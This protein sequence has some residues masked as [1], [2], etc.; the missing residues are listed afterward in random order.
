MFNA[1]LRSLSFASFL[2]ISSTC[3]AQILLPIPGKNVSVTGVSHKG[4]FSGWSENLDSSYAGFILTGDNNA[5]TYLPTLGGSSARA[6][7]IAESQL[8]PNHPY[9]VGESLDNLG[10]SRPFVYQNGAMADLGTLGG[11]SG[12][13]LSASFS[14]R[15]V[16]W[17]ET[18]SGQKLA[19]LWRLGIP[20]SL[21]TLGGNESCATGVNT[22]GYICGWSLNSEG[23]MRAFVW[24]QGTMSDL[25]T[26]GGRESQAQGMNS[27]GDIVGIAQ[28]SNGRY[29]PV[30]WRRDSSYQIEKLDDLKVTSTSIN[31]TG[32]CMWFGGK[33]AFIDGEYYKFQ[34]RVLNGFLPYEIGTASFITILGTVEAGNSKRIAVLE[35]NAP[36]TSRGI[37]SISTTDTN[38]IVPKSVSI[39]LDIAAGPNEVLIPSVSRPDLASVPALIQLSPGQREVTIPVLVFGVD[40]LAPIFVSATIG[41]HHYTVPEPIV[42]G[43]DF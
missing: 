15:F 41:I 14:G 3:L 17:S 1:I 5:V 35:V 32:T 28:E 27:N 39:T 7:G 29:L 10:R 6:L 11:N 2:V 23:R 33:S 24:F 25:G 16:G 26:L 30:V 13:A 12:A 9:V 37:G 21:G 38:V 18:L 22:M 43:T 8:M 40:T 42:V 4:S 36:P 20:T 34:D 19:T 31:S